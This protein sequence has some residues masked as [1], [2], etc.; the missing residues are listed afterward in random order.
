VASENVKLP[1]ARV[2]HPEEQR[3]RI[4]FYILVTDTSRSFTS[5]RMTVEKRFRPPIAN[6][7]RESA[8]N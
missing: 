7:R 2:C 8:R 5:F 3:R 4:C 6:C 1:G